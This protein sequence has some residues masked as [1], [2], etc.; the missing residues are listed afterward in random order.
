[1][2]RTK[3]IFATFIFPTQSLEG[4]PLS[5][6]KNIILLAEQRAPAGG[7]VGFKKKYLNR[8]TLFSTYEKAKKR[9][10]KKGGTL[11]LCLCDV[12]DLN[13]E[14]EGGTCRDTPC[15]EATSAVALRCWD[16]DV[17]DLGGEKVCLR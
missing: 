4:F 13:L 14:V 1:M 12:E 3:K 17:A 9:E 10:S 8:E 2:F 11:S 7:A 16:H 15:R 5:L 6:K